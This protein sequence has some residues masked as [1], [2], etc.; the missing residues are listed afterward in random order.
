MKLTLAPNK[1]LAY[2]K[3]ALLLCLHS[4]SLQPNLA[5][6]LTPT[7]KSRRSMESSRFRLTLQ[8]CPS[9]WMASPKE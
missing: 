7:S 9:L 1:Y 5:L 3:F 6:R 8:D 2:S 4:R